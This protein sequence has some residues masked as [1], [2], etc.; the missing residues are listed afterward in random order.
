MTLALTELKRLV[1]MLETVRP[2]GTGYLSVRTEAGVYTI[3]HPD[4]PIPRAPWTWAHKDAEPD[5]TPARHGTA[6]TFYDVLD[7][8]MGDIDWNTCQQCH[9]THD[10]TEQGRYCARCLAD[11]GEAQADAEAD[12]ADNRLAT[13]REAGL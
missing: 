5:D 2:A 3:G 12:A 6:R 9:R 4:A 1:A 8:I 11:M 10:V 7:E 13:I